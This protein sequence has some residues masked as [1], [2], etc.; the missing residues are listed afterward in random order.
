LSELN[1]VFNGMSYDITGPVYLPFTDGMVN[2]EDNWFGLSTGTYVSMNGG[3]AGEYLK[4]GAGNHV[5]VQL[6]S[7]EGSVTVVAVPEP[8]L[9]GLQAAVLIVLAG[10]RE[11]SAA[12]RVVGG[13]CRAEARLSSRLA[14]TQQGVLA[15]TR[16]EACPA[17]VPASPYRLRRRPIRGCSSRFIGP[18]RREIYSRGAVAVEV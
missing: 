17:G 15:G 7:T 18:A 6:T 16:L 13:H 2:S 14:P 9:A 5:D 1:V 10:I 12:G 8:A 4:Y 11:A 3:M